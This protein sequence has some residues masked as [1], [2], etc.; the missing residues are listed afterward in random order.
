MINYS[1][2]IPHYNRPNL[3][4]R[5]LNSIPIRNDIEVIIVDDNSPVGE[6]DYDRY[7]KEKQKN[8]KVLLTKEGK[9]AGYARNQG[10]EIAAGK[11]IIFA[12]SDDFFTENAFLIFDEYVN[13][14]YDLIYFGT[15]SCYSDTLK[16]A[17]RNKYYNNLVKEFSDLS[18]YHINNLRFKFGPPWA[19]MIRASMIGNAISK[20]IPVVKFDETRYSNDS[21]FSL[22][23]GY[24]AE[25]IHADSRKVYCVTVEFGS[26]IN[27]INLSS[28]RIRYEVQL[29]CN[30]FVCEHGFCK[31]QR[32]LTPYLRMAVM[33]G[34]LKSLIEFLRL[35]K[36]YNANYFFGYKNWPKSFWLLIS[37][38]NNKNQYITNEDI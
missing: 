17:D 19:K 26:L 35:G 6:F 5:L 31:Y 27:T 36:Q 11:W 14:D 12:D 3:L 20:G 21:M 28:I 38:S 33:H 34:G 22:L 1:I 7:W 8:Y 23:I 25:T 4:D 15:E 30:Q 9:G 18:D 10:L 37:K 16:P 29:R 13:S 24:L 2:I 32:T